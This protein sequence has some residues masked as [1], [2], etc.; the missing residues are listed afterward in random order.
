[1]EKSDS[2]RIASD[3]YNAS[4]ADAEFDCLTIHFLSFGGFFEELPDF[5]RLR[6][7]SNQSR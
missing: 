3:Y 4:E 2:E 1:M 5:E 7:C 6:T